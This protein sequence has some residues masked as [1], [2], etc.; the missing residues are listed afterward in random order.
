MAEDY[1]LS[2]DDENI[3][4]VIGLEIALADEVEFVDIDESAKTYGNVNFTSGNEFLNIYV[5]PGK[6]KLSIKP[7]NKGG[8]IVYDV[9][10]VA[11]HPKDRAPASEKLFEI[12]RHNVLVKYK[13]GNGAYKLIGTHLEHA[14][15]NIKQLEPASGGYNGYEITIEGKFSQ[16]PLY[17]A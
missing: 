15:I 7:K 13:T 14:Q 16:A 6:S 11:Y 1:Y 9:K 12:A 17:E 2:Q 3:S 5:T 8:N 4:S 10:L